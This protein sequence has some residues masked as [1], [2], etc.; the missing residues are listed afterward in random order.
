MRGEKPAHTAVDEEEL[1]DFDISTD[2]DAC[3]LRFD[4]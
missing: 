2:I 3:L 4:S 1:L